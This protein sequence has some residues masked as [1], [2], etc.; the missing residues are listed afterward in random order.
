MV[1][2]G[3]IVYMGLLPI[4]SIVDFW[5]V[6]TRV[7]QVADYMSRN[8]FKT[9]RSTLHFND[10]DQAAGSQD[11]F[12]KVRALFTKVSREFLKVPETPIH[13]ID[14]IIQAP[15]ICRGMSR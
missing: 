13:S 12:F 7:P 1:F 2:L 9:I 4:P 15:T 8:R 10:N 6:H 11:R 5:A 3:L 14:D